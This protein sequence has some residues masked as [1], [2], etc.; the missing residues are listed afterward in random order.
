M[1]DGEQPAGGTEAHPDEPGERPEPSG[2][3][4]VARGEKDGHRPEAEHSTDD[5]VAQVDGFAVSR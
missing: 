1:V 5:G 4:V 2:P 3:T